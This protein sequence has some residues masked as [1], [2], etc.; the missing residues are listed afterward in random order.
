MCLN[1]MHDWAGWLLLLFSFSIVLMWKSI[2]DDTKVVHAIWLCLVLHHAVV[3]LNVYIPDASSFHYNGVSLAVLPE[4]EWFFDTREG[5][6]NY[7]HL[8]GFLYRFLAHHF[9]LVRNC[10]FWL[11]YCRA[12]C[13]LNWQIIQILGA[14]V[15]ALYLS[16]VCCLQR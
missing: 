12:W 16:L 10:R 6:I 4:P 8:L 14:F 2:R 9:F 1:I 15:L 7:I 3:F 11:L 5:T 13:W